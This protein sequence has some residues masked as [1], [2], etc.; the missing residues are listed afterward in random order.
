MEPMA[1][2]GAELYVGFQHHPL[3]GPVISVGLGGMLLELTGDVAFRL[4]PAGKADFLEMLGELNA[5]PKLKKGFR[6]FPAVSEDN[7]LEI[8]SKV[9]DL[10]LSREDIKELDLN[11]VVARP[12][13]CRWWM[14]P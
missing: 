9:A 1:P 3:F 5:W 8:I 13:G 4:L 14:R 10:A 12:T 6:H 2:A 11:P 7:L